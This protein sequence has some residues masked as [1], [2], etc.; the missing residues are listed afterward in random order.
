ML[1]FRKK[2]IPPFAPNDNEGNFFSALLG[3]VALA[4]QSRDLRYLEAEEYERLE[5]QCDSIAQ[6]LAAL[7]RSLRSRK[8]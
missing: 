6:M 5:R 2:Q 1:A 8:A 3:A 4:S 7:S